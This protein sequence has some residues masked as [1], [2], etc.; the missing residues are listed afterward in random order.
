LPGGFGERMV[1]HESQLY[2]I[3]AA[4]EDRVAVLTEPLSIGVHAILQV[5]PDPRATVLVVGSG[6]IALG[7]VWALR[8][9]GHD[10]SIV[11]QT[12]R[13]NEAALAK[14]LGAS[15]AVS[16][17]AEAKKALFETG[18]RAYKPLVGPEVFG[19]GGFDFVFD[20]VGSRES[21]DQS[22]RFVAP[23]GTIVLLGCAGMIGAMD[24]TFLWAREVRIAGFL[25]YGT[26]SFRGDTLHTFEVTHHLLAETRAPVSKLVTH[27]FPLSRYREALR[28]AAR[29]AESGAMKVLLDPRAK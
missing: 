15:A 12:K 19:G 5:R 17:G 8:A 16:P 4:L 2:P 9:L 6:P 21:L 13:A 24:L 28:A 23:R 25:C 11:A 20:C 7:T 18:A 26:E 14:E 22:L 3:R 1:V 29:R 10:G 27:T